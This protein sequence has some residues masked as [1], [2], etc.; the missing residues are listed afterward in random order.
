[1]KKSVMLFGVII[2]LAAILRLYGLGS[3][4]PSLNWDEISHGYNA[5]SILKT[6]SDEWG[7]FLP[8]AN[9]R[10]YGD[11]PLPLNLYLTIPFIWLMGLTEVSIRLP[12]AILGILTVASSYFFALGLTKKKP[13]ALLTAFFVAIEPWTLFTSRFVVQSNLSIFFLSLSAALFV[14]REKN[15]WFVPLSVLSLGLTLFS[16]HTTRIFSPLIL[17][18]ALVIYRNEVISNLRK[19][20]L[21][22]CITLGVILIFFIPLILILTNKESRA[23]S[24]EVFL[25]DQGAIN[26]IIEKRQTTPLPVSVAKL[27][28]NRPVYLLT[29]SAKNY[30]EYFSPRF[31]F[32][33]GGTQYQFSIPNFGLMYLASLP[34]FYVG[35]YM[36]MKS[37]KVNKDYVLII[38]WLLLAPLP[39]AI[40]KEHFAVLRSSAMLPL[41][42]FI[43]AL[44]FVSL[45]E[46]LM[47]K[48]QKWSAKLLVIAFTLMLLVNTSTYIMKYFYEYPNDYSQD[49]QYGYKQVVSY[50]NDNHSHYDK[51]I[52]TKFYGEPH[53]F[54]LFYSS[55]DPQKYK[56]DPKLNRFSQA[57]WYWVDGFDKFYFVNDWQIPKIGEKFV[58]ESKGEVNCES[59]KCLLITRPGNH[60]EGWTKLKEVNF[61][62]DQTAFEMYDNIK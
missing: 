17:F 60:P 24:S 15:R 4:P 55:W 46:S 19:F 33:K 26:H 30:L 1:M 27:V 45:Y 58:Q 8:I 2:F 11:Y 9:F 53:E 29:N 62:N 18:T 47:G 16:Y 5:F 6:G 42:Q 25:I 39:A 32:F 40:T 12:H 59:E 35:L 13:V 31:L 57:N 7:K 44:G 51:I 56:A 36:L 3:F 54:I 37:T 28:Y 50:I 22:T 21:L 49:W 38:G 34:F 52:V 14:N 48:G 43:S 61:L 23:R 20:K 41:P 10:A